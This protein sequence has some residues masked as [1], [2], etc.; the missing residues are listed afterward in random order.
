MATASVRKAHNPFRTPD[1]TPT[2]TGQS[3]TL[4][5]SSSSSATEQVAAP[6]ASTP[7]FLPPPGPPPSNSSPQPSTPAFSPPPGP[8][9]SHPSPQP[10]MLAELN[11]EPPPAYSITPNAY[12]GESTIEF[13]PRRPFTQAPPPVQALSP[14][15]SGSHTPSVAVTPAHTG[16]NWAN[17]PGARARPSN[18]DRAGTTSSR[19]APPPRHPSQTTLRPPPRSPPGPSPSDFAQTMSDFARDFYAAGGGSPGSQ[20]LNTSPPPLPARSPSTRYAPPPG[21][22]P[23]SPSISGGR[24]SSYPPASPTTSTA[25]RSGSGVP[26]DGRPTRTP[27]PGHPLLRNNE[28]LVYP[29]GY[30]CDKCEPSLLFLSTAASRRTSAQ[31][32]TPDTSTSTP[33]TRAVSVGSAT[34]ARTTAP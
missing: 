18:L 33:R 29:A 8:P 26:D 6:Q 12:D 15:P 25:P 32:T 16:G 28:I 21:P 13:G 31:A 34:R 20:G 2:P 4:P 23:Q 14:Q 11:A 1:V 7:A 9:P 30:E 22:P 10:S 5:P 27:V 17:Y 24:P 3:S 19:R